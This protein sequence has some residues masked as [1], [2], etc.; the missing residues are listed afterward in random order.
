MTF[1][2]SS[3][4]RVPTPPRGDEVA[5]YDTY[6]EAQQA[7]DFL[8]DEKF[9]V[10]HVTIVGTDLRM[11]ERVT[12]RLTY[13]RV[14]LAG[15]LSG[16]WFGFFVGLLLTFFG[17]P[18]AG[19][20]I[21]AAIALGAGFGLLFSVLSYAFTGGSRDFTSQSQIVAS[22]YAI[23]CATEHAGEARS[24]LLKSPGGLGKARQ[25][26]TPAAPV[27]TG[28]DPRWTTPT[29]E[30]R[31]GAMRPASGTPATPRP[32]TPEQASG[33]TPEQRPEQPDDA[34]P[35]QPAPPARPSSDPYA[36]PSEDDRRS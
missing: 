8:S 31:Y 16:A 21:F 36:P 4:P 33:Q 14:A 6:L 19:G 34:S 28:P 7:V 9:P 35:E 30:P 11:V 27:R 12:G 22:T 10:Q 24:L 1:S 32:A 25:T 15:A 2:R 20:V 23:L 17:G 29:G 26:T 3:A 13:G 18:E 5:A